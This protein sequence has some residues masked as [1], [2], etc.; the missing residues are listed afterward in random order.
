MDVAGMAP[1]ARMVVATADGT[2]HVVPLAGEGSPDLA[3]IEAL[4][5]FQLL[6][7][8]AGDQMWLEDVSAALAELLD[9]AGLRRQ[10]AEQLSTPGQ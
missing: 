7:R 2:R 5:Q 3:L 4:A 9:L 10:L 1:W 6:A 8:R